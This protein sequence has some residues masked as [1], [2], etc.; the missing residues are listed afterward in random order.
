MKDIIDSLNLPKQILDKTEKLMSKLFGSSIKEF[1]ELFAD[2]VRYRRLRNQ[3]KIFNK[4]RELLDKNGLES[5]ELNLKTIVPLIEKSSVEEDEILQDKWANLIASMACTP[6]NG[7]EPRLINT[8]SSLS[9]LEAKILDYIYEDIYIQKQLKLARLLDSKVKKYTE[10]DILTDD[11]EVSYDSIQE[12]FEL[13]DNFI[14]I[15]IDNFVAL[16]LVKYKEPDVDIDQGSHSAGI[17]EDDQEGKTVDL[18]LELSAT[19]NTSDNIHLTAF[20]N[21]FIGQCKLAIA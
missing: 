21:Y 15:Y 16:G 11:I 13:D 18:N 4:T 6:E 8:L 20:G 17:D 10:K 9:S 12:S 7:L 5:R 14:R 19:F 2:N 3:I 1:G